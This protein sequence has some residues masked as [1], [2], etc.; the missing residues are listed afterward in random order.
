[1][2]WDPF[3]GRK[4]VCVWDT[5][6]ARNGE[7]TPK[8]GEVYTIRDA[9]SGV[10]ASERIYI[11]LAEIV[12]EPRMYVEGTHECNFYKGAFRPLVDRQT[13]ISVF[14]EMLLTPRVLA[15]EQSAQGRAGESSPHTAGRPAE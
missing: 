14:R 13:D 3:V 7:I 12:N 4:V 15:T 9:E 6:D 8:K 2:D 5:W 1:M 10:T 11:R